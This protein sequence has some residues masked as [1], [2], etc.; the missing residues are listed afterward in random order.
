MTATPRMFVPLNLL[1]GSDSALRH[2][3]CVLLAFIALM[4]TPTGAMGAVGRGGNCRNLS[5]QEMSAN[6]D[7]ISS[8]V[9]ETGP[10]EL[11]VVGAAHRTDLHASATLC[12]RSEVHLETRRESSTLRVIASWSASERRW[13]LFGPSTALVVSLDV[14]A[15]ARIEIV[16]SYGPTSIR[17]VA[18]ATVRGGIGTLHIAD[19][20]GDVIAHNGVGATYIRSVGGDVEVE[21]GA[22]EMIVSNVGG[23]LR[24]LGDTGG[25]IVIDDVR[26][27]VVI[28]GDGSGEISI[29]RVAGDVRV[30]QDGE[31]KIL[32][33][34]VGGAFSVEEKATGLIKHT[35]VAGPVNV[36]I[37]RSQPRSVRP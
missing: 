23:T 19:V 5:V 10:S 20:S 21:D 15:N 7:G 9:I 35:R 6:L 1:Q 27:D 36:P 14:P 8:I 26:R 28:D 12:G 37:M 31:G 2:C 30:R 33:R 17:D 22:G 11:R 25:Q 13:S 24:I 18:A 34:D 4:I 16:E 29:A 32:V 3:A